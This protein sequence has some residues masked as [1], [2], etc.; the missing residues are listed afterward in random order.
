MWPQDGLRSSQN[1]KRPAGGG[2]ALL[3]LLQGGENW[4]RGEAEPD[5]ALPCGAASGCRRLY[6]VRQAINWRTAGASCGAENDG[7]RRLG[8][9]RGNALSQLLK[10]ILIGGDLKSRVDYL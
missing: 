3:G 5:L 7:K 4:G 2:G 1:R 10:V 6:P 9:E 8:G